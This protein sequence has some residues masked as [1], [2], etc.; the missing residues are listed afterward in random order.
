MTDLI[1]RCETYPKAR[2]SRD[3]E[4]ARLAARTLRLPALH[5]VPPLSAARACFDLGRL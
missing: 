2:A 5:R 4:F 1:L 3:G